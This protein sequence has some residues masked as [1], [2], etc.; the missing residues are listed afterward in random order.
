[1][2]KSRRGVYYDLSKTP[3]IIK[4]Y[5]KEY[6]FSSQKKLDMFKRKVERIDNWY[7]DNKTI[8]DK[9]D[10]IEKFISNLYDY[11]YENMRYK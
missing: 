9:T 6:R 2:I 7:Q 10:N 4:K 8:L 5:D 11:K 1:M 3:Y